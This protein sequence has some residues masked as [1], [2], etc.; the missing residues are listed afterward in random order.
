MYTEKEFEEHVEITTR[1]LKDTY[2]NNIIYV[3]ERIKD[4]AEESEIKNIE[5]LIIANERMIVYFDQNDDW[6]KQLHEEARGKAGDDDASNDDGLGDDSGDDE[7]EV[8]RI[9]EARNS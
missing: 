5:D 7:E 4:G 8:A 1:I 9:E 3:Q 6:V 2:V